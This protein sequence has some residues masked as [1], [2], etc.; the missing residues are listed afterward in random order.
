MSKKNEVTLRIHGGDAQYDSLK[1]KVRTTNDLDILVL[2][3]HLLIQEELQVLLS[4]R[5]G[6]RELPRLNFETL[7]SLALAGSTFSR[8]R[9][10]IEHLNRAR[11]GIAHQIER[12]DAANELA[13][14]CSAAQPF[15]HYDELFT[16]PADDP[17]RLHVLRRASYAVIDHLRD[18][19]QIV[20]TSHDALRRHAPHAPKPELPLPKT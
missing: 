18:L 17:G 14:Y 9:R 13:Q 12:R 15:A 10:A 1:E 3:V 16:W 4:F 11:N 5:L 7:L 6:A 8:A 20:Q 19:M 2:L